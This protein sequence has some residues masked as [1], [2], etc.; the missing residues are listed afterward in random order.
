MALTIAAAVAA[1]VAT[2]VVIHSTTGLS[3]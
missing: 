1:W 2:R 3:R